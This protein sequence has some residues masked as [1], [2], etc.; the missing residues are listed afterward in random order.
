MLFVAGLAAAYLTCMAAS[1]VWALTSE[2]R[3]RRDVRR[4]Q[5]EVARARTVR[6]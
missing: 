3:W 1:A 5:H 6:R 2:V 4:A